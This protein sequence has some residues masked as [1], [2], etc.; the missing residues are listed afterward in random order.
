[1]IWAVSMCRT[2]RTRGGR[3]KEEREGMYPTRSIKQAKKGFTVIHAEPSRGSPSR[4]TPRGARR[5]RSGR[6]AGRQRNHR[7]GSWPRRDC[8]RQGRARC[9][10]KWHRQA[11][12][13][14][15]TTIGQSP[16]RCHA[17]TRLTSRAQT[18]RSPSSRLTAC[19]WVGNRNRRLRTWIPSAATLQ[20]LSR[21]CATGWR[22]WAWPRA[23]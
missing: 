5:S 13:V 8:C 21:L 15:A 22:R 9:R 2:Y 3:R 23:T 16:L 6:D 12:S 17:L 4:D 1:M 11:G 19:L 18:S 10:Q 14:C 20:A 7:Q